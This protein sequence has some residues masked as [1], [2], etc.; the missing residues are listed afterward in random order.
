M[1]DFHNG[2]QMIF[3]K[4]KAFHKLSQKVY[5]EVFLIFYLK[6]VFHI[7]F[8]SHKVFQKVIY[9]IY[10]GPKLTVFLGA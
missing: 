2:S 7:V 9:T 1:K 8:I 5:R 6:E 3:N 10:H 4:G